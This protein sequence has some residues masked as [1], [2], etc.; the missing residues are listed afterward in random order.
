MSSP[1]TR[2]ASVSSRVR[3]ADCYRLTNSL[4]VHTPGKRGQAVPE[5]RE[6]SSSK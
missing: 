2:R 5:T 6:Y 4:T 1:L 3:L